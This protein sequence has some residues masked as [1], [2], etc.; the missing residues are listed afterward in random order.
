MS[1][2]QLPTF[3]IGGT[4]VSSEEPRP[5]KPIFTKE[6]V[7]VYISQES[8]CIGSVEGYLDPTAKKL[9]LDIEI[10]HVTD[11]DVD[12]ITNIVKTYAL[13]FVGIAANP[14]PKVNPPSTTDVLPKA[15]FFDVIRGK[16]GGVIYKIV[17]GVQTPIFLNV[18]ACPEDNTT[19]IVV[20]ENQFQTDGLKTHREALL[21]I[22]FKLDAKRENLAGR[23]KSDLMLLLNEYAR[24]KDDVELVVAELWRR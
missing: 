1:I 22:G 10:P 6:K 7:P 16:S 21:E 12:R 14:T 4:S 5:L 8:R 19:R 13:A 3:P 11:E 17:E 20:G 15:T 24:S 9:H 23:Y 2:L 18:V